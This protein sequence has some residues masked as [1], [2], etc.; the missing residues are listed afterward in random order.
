MILYYIIF[1]YIETPYGGHRRPP[2]WT[3]AYGRINN[4]NQKYYL[5]VIINNGCVASVVSHASP[6]NDL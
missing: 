4:E 2:S 6:H 1:H 3:P 5:K